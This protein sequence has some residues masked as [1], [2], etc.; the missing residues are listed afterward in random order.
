MIH[1]TSYLK[2][3]QDKLAVLERALAL[4]QQTYNLLRSVA[5]EELGVAPRDFDALVRLAER[6]EWD[7]LE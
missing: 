1:S 3:Y 7:L 6:G 2:S 4:E 5:R